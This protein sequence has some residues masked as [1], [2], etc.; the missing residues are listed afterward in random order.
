MDEGQQPTAADQFAEFNGRYL[1]V[2]PIPCYV[3]ESGAVWVERL[4]HHDLVEHL[5]YLKD[6]VLCAPRLPHDPKADLVRFRVPDGARASFAFLP[7]Q[8]SFVRA[9]LHLPRTAV[10]LWRAIGDADIVH[11]TVGGWPYPLGWI[12]NPVA[13]LRRKRLVIVVESPWRMGRRGW[14]HRL[15]DMDPLRDWM[16]RW[17]CNRAHLALFTHASYRDALCGRN[18]KRAYVTPAVWVNDA[19]ILGDTAAEAAWARKVHEPVRLLF[20]GRLVES[21]GIGVLLA[22]LRSLDAL[23]VEGCVDIVGQGPLRDACLQAA[24]ESRSVRLRVLEPV[25]YG[26]PF[27]QLVGRYHTV[28]VPSLSDEQPRIVFDANSQAVPVIASDTNGLRPHVDNGKTG[29]LVPAGDVSALV[30]AIARAVGAAT[31]LRA[32]GLAALRMSRGF[33]H[34]AMHRRRSQLLRKHCVA[35]DL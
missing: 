6:F 21:K 16:A 23:G 29:W 18:G 31:Q 27:F 7:P 34:K 3:D 12:T 13:L 4:W 10:V 8:T 28:L 2:I 5:T 11:S 32:M 17:A 14:K 19:D 33:T 22:A 30:T 20:A 26:Q 24:S 9:M 1:L 15:M 25:P 35:A